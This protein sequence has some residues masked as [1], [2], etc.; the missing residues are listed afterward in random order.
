MP[1]RLFGIPTPRLSP[2]ATPVLRGN[3]NRKYLDACVKIRNP[4]RV[5]SMQDNNHPQ[6]VQLIEEFC[7]I[8][9]EEYV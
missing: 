2:T 8:V 1:C 4:P 5:S 9:V 6:T 3:P 7:H